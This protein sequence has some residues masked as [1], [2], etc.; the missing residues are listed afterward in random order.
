VQEGTHKK[1]NKDRNLKTT[2]IIQDGVPFTV[3]D[4]KKQTED[5][6]LLSAVSNAD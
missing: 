1:I 5:E 6:Q 2:R 4:V 3:Q